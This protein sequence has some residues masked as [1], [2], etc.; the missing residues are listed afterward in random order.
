MALDTT[1]IKAGFIIAF[2]LFASLY[3]GIAAATAKTET[4]L[5]IF[6]VTVVL[7]CVGLGH[8]VYLLIPLLTSLGYVLPLPGNL[9][10]EMIAQGIVIGFSLLLFFLRRLPLRLGFTELEL[11]CLLLLGMVGLAYLRNPV[12]LNVFGTAAVGAKPY[13]IFGASALT[14]ALLSQL[15]INPK[16]LRLW[17]RLVMI[18]S[19]LN[20]GIGLIGTIFPR[21]ML[22]LGATYSTDIETERTEGKATRISFVRSLS[23]S[24]TTWISSRVSPLAASFHPLWFWLVLASLMMAAFSGFRGQLIYVGLIF[25]A[26]VCYRGGARSALASSLLL[27]V[28]LTVLSIFNIASPLPLNIQ[29]ALTFLPGK[30]DPVV[31]QD[32][33]NST[34]WR[35]DMWKEALFSDRW[36]ENK[37]LGDGLGFSKQEL[38]RMHGFSEIGS[39]RGISG[40]TVQ[41]ESFMISGGYHSGP[42][43]TIRTIGYVGLVVLLFAMIRLAVHAHRQIRRCRGTEWLPVA[44][45][46]GIPLIVMPLYWSLVFGTFDRGAAGVMMGAALVRLMEKNLPLPAYVASKRHRHALALQPFEPDVVAERT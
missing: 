38:L 31:R 14:A 6:V 27:A 29:R 36:I 9:S 32:A 28:G 43:H 40:L 30:W 23:A 22:V 39:H 45:F 21:T 44:L 25:L 8:R 46:L 18:G 10:S 7:T 12:G 35:L 2:A 33:Q 4:F 37:W 26:G 19:F 20:F 42:V 5:W 13:A 16:D 1:K 17:V 11:W 3:L 24:L 34:D 41:Q 15:K